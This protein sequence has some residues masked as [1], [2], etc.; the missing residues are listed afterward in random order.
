[1][2]IWCVCQAWDPTETVDSSLQRIS[3]EMYIIPKFVFYTR[4]GVY[5]AINHSVFG[6]MCIN[7]KTTIMYV[8]NCF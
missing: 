1:M 6:R 7:E 4:I 3:I 5:D 2:Y 8:Y